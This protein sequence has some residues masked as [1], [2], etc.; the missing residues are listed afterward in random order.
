MG[1]K[2]K[3]LKQAF[4]LHK[5]WKRWIRQRM[6]DYGAYLR[7]PPYA[8]ENHELVI[9]TRDPV[10]YTTVALAIHSLDQAKVTGSFAEVGVYRGD[11]SRILHRLA[12]NRRLYLFDTFEGFPPQD[13][14]EPDE[15]FKET[16]L[17]MLRQMLGDL[18]NVVIRKGYFP[19]TARGLEN[20]R[21]AF[22]MLDVDKYKP[23]LAGLQFFYPRLVRHGYLMVHDYNSPESNWAVSK[24][25]NEFMSDKPEQIIQVADSGG[26]GL[27]RKTGA[28]VPSAAS[29]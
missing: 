3:H 6:L 4:I 7:F 19:D 27:I 21:F 15:R 14:D 17:D 20:E 5:L 22:V 1:Q 29:P 8:A 18:N 11:S 24:A 23:T 25:T 12:P 26:S 9:S 13:T 10:R 16:S 2:L 28:L